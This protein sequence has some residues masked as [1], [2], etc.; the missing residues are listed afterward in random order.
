MLEEAVSMLRT[1]MTE[2]RKEA[3]VPQQEERERRERGRER[4]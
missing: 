1:T 2:V 4:Q 3:D